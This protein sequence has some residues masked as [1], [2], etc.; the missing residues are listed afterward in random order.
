MSYNLLT[1]VTNIQTMV[2]TIATTIKAAPVAPPEAMNQFPFSLVYI[3]EFESL[4]GSYHWDEVVD[5]IVIEIHFTRQNLPSAYKAALACRIEI[6]EKLIADPRIG[7]SVDTF[8]DF[9]GN[10]G[11]MEYAGTG[12]IGWQMELDVKGKITI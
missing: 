10:F 2:Q 3:K 11:Y 5:T 12:T 6:F 9:R 7:D 4:G 1:A 8:T